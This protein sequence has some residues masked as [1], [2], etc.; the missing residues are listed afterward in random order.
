MKTT[1]RRFRA[2]DVGWWSNTIRVLTLAPRVML[3]SY[4]LPTK[5]SSYILVDTTR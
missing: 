3:G 4:F 1:T 5:R 2:H